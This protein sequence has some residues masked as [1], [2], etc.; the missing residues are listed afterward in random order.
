M[1]IKKDSAFE[2]DEKVITINEC[3]ET[4]LEKTT[5]DSYLQSDD[6]SLFGDNDDCSFVKGYN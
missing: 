3:K 6:Y 1:S 2:V 5:Q 4:P